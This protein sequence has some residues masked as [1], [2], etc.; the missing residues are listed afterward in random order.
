MY[1][2][3]FPFW[4]TAGK[5]GVE[6]KLRVYVTHDAEAGVFIAT[7]DDL[8]GMVAEAETM[9]KLVTEVHSTIE[10]LMELEFHGQ[11]NRHPVTDLRLCAA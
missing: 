8:R 5:M 3:G 6:L 11:P 7:S 1:R 2:I 4:K 10:S 9:D